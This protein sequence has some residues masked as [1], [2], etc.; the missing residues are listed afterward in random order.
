MH[1]E[2][3]ESARF[4]SFAEQVKLQYAL[5][6]T[7]KMLKIFVTAGSAPWLLSVG[8]PGVF[9]VLCIVRGLQWARMTQTQLPEDLAAA[10]MK[11]SSRLVLVFGVLFLAVDIALYL[12]CG[13]EERIFMIVLMLMT[14]VCQLFYFI[15][16]PQASTITASLYATATVALAI[17]NGNGIVI[18]IALTI[19]SMIAIMSHAVYCHRNEFI[20]L[21]SAHEQLKRLGAE[22]ERL[23]STDALTGLPNRREFFRAIAAAHRRATSTGTYFAIGIA[24]LDDFKSANDTYGHSVGDQV[25]AKVATRMQDVVGQRAKAYRIGGDEFA[26]IFDDAVHLDLLKMT[27]EGIIASISQPMACDGADVRVGCSIGLALFPQSTRDIGKLYE[28][29][30]EALYASKRR[31]RG[32][33]TMFSAPGNE[34]PTKQTMAS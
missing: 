27:A 22:N 31:G 19:V 23:A 11:Q 10:A 34:N 25:L 18:A 33:V 13:P 8:I 28:A 26:L 15:Y 7:F 2:S 3:L 29:A 30:D 1:S 17:S 14:C 20:A 21:V 9:A 16:L 24:D 32:C 6:V 4:A 5:A 12:Y